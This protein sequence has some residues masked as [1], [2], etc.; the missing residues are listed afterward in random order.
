M[1]NHHT[2]H[3]HAHCSG[4]G[5][6]C[7]AAHH[8]EQSGERRGHEGHDAAES[9]HGGGDDDPDHPAAR[10]QGQCPDHEHSH[11]CCEPGHPHGHERSHDCC[12]SG[13]PHGHEHSHDCCGDG[14]GCGH[15]HDEAVTAPGEKAMTLLGAALAV[16]AF[17]PAAGAFAPWLMA[18]GTLLIGYPLFL[19]GI[20]GLFSGRAFDELGLLTV[21]VAASLG[22]AATSPDPFEG[23][24]EALAVTAFFRLGNALEARAVAKSQ[25]DIEALTSIRPDT[26]LRLLP[27]GSQ[28][29]VPAESVAPGSTI[30]LKPGDRVPID[31]EVLEGGGF[32]DLSVITGEPIPAEVRPGSRIPSGGIN[33]DGLLT[34][35]TTASFED[36]AAS[37]IIRMVRDSAEQKGSAERFITR[38][39][40][41]Y[42]PAVVIIAAALALLPPLFGFGSLSMW[43][44]RALVFLVASCPC[45]LVISVPLTF[46]AGVGTASRAGV[47]VKGTRYL[48]ALAQTDCA[49]FDKTGTLTLGAPAV[50]EFIVAPG[51]SREE[52]LPLAA[53]A[54]Q[55]SNHPAA[56]AVLAYAGAPRAEAVSDF[57]EHPG[58]GV[59]LTVGGRKLLCGSARLFE[60]YGVDR[61]PLPAANVLLAVDGRAAGAFLLADRPREEAKRALGELRALGVGTIAILTGDAKPAAEAAAAALGID[62]VRAGLMPGDKAE[63]LALLQRSHRSTVFVGDGINDAPVLVRADVGIAMGLGTDTAIE[64]A[65]VVLVREN[66]TALPAAI[67]IARRTVRKARENIA[68]A[69]V[70]KLAVLLLGAMGLATMWMAVFADVG[71]SILAI[72]NS[73]TLLRKENA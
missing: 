24:L 54:E 70:V 11:D 18:A 21:A 13:H 50:S 45:A 1:S 71:V 43:I 25:R 36:S 62:T 73:L 52:L 40:K 72:L 9:P 29:S 57:T 56:R 64:S 2:H 61:A 60:K 16:F 7:C 66:L 28:Q 6:A 53:A 47:L 31:C 65:D 38:F 32:V 67:R 68:F 15:S 12:E 23:T 27:D 63:Q 14:C 3:E 5:C 46:F 22:L 59:S 35:R 17:L 4:Q 41:I 34:C 49:A 58:M 30:L 10:P 55:N 69:L 8:Q 33:T 20:T 19:S 42:T 37:R 44:S 51:F 26:A 48:E 39:S